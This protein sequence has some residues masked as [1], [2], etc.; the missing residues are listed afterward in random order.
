VCPDDSHTSSLPDGDGGSVAFI[1]AAMTIA[2]VVM[3][4]AVNGRKDAPQT[5]DTY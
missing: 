5:Q 1:T 4:A 2:L 3:Y